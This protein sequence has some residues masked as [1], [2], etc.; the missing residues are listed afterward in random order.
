MLY[1]IFIICGTK[2][3]VCGEKRI[4]FLVVDITVTGSNFEH[5]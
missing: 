3:Q 2:L 1:A 5:E 4:F